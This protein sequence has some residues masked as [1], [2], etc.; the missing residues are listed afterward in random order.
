MNTIKQTNRTILFEKINEE[1]EDL[2]SIIGNVEG[3]E[4][5]NSEIKKKINEKLVVESFEEFLNKFEPTIYSY[6]DCEKGEMIYSIEK[7]ST[8]SIAEERLIKTKLNK[9]DS[10]L[11]MILNL[12]EGREKIGKKLIEFDFEKITSML[13]PKSIVEDIKLTRKELENLYLEYEETDD[14]NPKKDD[15]ALALNAKFEAIRQTYNTPF[16]ILPLAIEDIKQR[17]LP[18]K[19][20]SQSTSTGQIRIGYTKFTEDGDLELIEYH[21][22]AKSLQS[23]ENKAAAL[24]GYIEADYE[25]NAGESRSDFT[26]ALVVRTFVPNV[27]NSVCRDIQR[28]VE[29]YDKY[30]TLYKKDKENFINA[31]RELMKKIIGI[32]LFFEQSH[33][34]NN[35]VK[36]RLLIT[37]TSV[38]MCIKNKDR[39]EKYLESTNNITYYEETLWLAIVPNVALEKP[40]TEAPRGPFQVKNSTISIQENNSMENLAV[41]IDM[42][43]KFRIQTFFNFEANE[44]TTF[45]NMEKNGIDKYREKTKDFI[46]KKYSEFSIVCFPN[47]TILPKDKS[48]VYMSN[49]LGIENNAVC[50]QDEIIKIL[51]DGIYID[52]SYVAAGIV[53]GYQSP[54]YLKK[55]L[56]KVIVTNPGVRFNLEENNNNLKFTTNMAKEIDGVIGKILDNINQDNFGFVF[57][58]NNYYLSGE[59]VNN[60]VVYKARSLKLNGDYYQPICETTTI[61]YFTRILKAITNDYQLKELE[62]FFNH[63]KG[64]MKIWE[65]EKEKGYDNLILKGNDEV[66]PTIDKDSKK[67][68]L[69]FKFDGPPINL[70]VEIN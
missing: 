67:C 21:Q 16:T 20:S 28:E 57:S 32:K 59:L 27:S 12:I 61:T 8:G 7:P 30:M 11:K 5:V 23:E 31:A 62:N 4:S 66:H 26:K 49:K 41:L 13:T 39:I 63:P 10:I 43:A 64:Q 42:M 29:N 19:T 53:A 2:L 36:P 34:D 22:E 54:Y 17:L 14:E 6:F 44:K 52:A 9:D 37:N 70:E 55:K 58:S 24:I 3:I 40:I 69:D 51:I 25:E 65:I 45:Q 50:A 38:E 47:F 15:L 46:S 56:S 68:S 35:E 18:A 33:V 48:L 60:I 1:K